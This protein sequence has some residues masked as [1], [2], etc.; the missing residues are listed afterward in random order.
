MMIDHVASPLHLLIFVHIMYP[1]GTHTHTAHT[2][3]LLSTWLL[4][5][6][7]NFVCKFFSRTV[8]RWRYE[9][10]GKRRR[11]TWSEGRSTVREC[12]IML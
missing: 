5:K 2:H 7:T 1:R 8:L 6:A 3:R 11:S 10:H 12:S 4:E 9:T